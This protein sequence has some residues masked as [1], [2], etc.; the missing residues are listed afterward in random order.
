M[1]NNDKSPVVYWTSE[2]VNTGEVEVR[3]FKDNTRKEVDKRILKGELNT[4]YKGYNKKW[5]R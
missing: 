5:I 1:K 4:N 2:W 3:H